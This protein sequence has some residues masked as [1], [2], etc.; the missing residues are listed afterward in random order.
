MIG[1]ETRGR[2]EMDVATRNARLRLAVFVSIVVAVVCL[3]LMCGFARLAHFSF[4]LTL[5]LLAIFLVIYSS[6]VA[7]GLRRHMP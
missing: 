2:G 5:A 3:L 4:S 6:G 1:K 7:R